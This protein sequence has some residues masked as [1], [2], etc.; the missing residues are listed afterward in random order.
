MRDQYGFPMK[1][2]NEY[3]SMEE[4][5][6]GKVQSAVSSRRSNPKVFPFFSPSNAC[7]YH[8]LASH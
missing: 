8:N 6:G 7:F 1:D 5:G 3:G 2:S 4:G